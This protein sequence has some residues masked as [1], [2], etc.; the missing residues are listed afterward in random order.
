M[1]ILV[2]GD[3]LEVIGAVEFPD[4][5]QIVRSGITLA[6]ALALEGATF[7][8]HGSDFPTVGVQMLSQDNGN[9]TAIYTR[10]NEVAA[11]QAELTAKEAELAESKSALENIRQAIA[12]LGTGIPTLTKLTAFLS[13]V[14]EAIHYE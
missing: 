8:I 5:V 9:V 7:T 11:L 13:A 6:D 12:D 4:M 14:K 10:P 3:S 1:E 2:N